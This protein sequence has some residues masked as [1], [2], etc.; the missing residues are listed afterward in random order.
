MHLWAAVKRFLW[1]L[2]AR[3]YELQLNDWFDLYV[4]TLGGCNQS[5]GSTVFDA[6]VRSWLWSTA[7]SSPLGYFSKLLK[8]TPHFVIINPTFCGSRFSTRRLQAIEDFAFFSTYELV[9]QDHTYELQYR[10]SIDLYVLTYELQVKDSFVLCVHTYELQ[11]RDSFDLYVPILWIKY[12]FKAFIT[13]IKFKNIVILIQ[14]SKYNNI[15]YTLSVIHP[16]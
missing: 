15:S 4:H 1:A 10:D 14:I 7:S 16:Q 6:M 3:N 9:F 11:L 13:M 12:Y 8:L 5:I 2:C